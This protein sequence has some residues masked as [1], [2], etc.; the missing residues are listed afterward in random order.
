MA[1]RSD[2]EKPS[3]TLL[4][5]RTM[6][7]LLTS[8]GMDSRDGLDE[9]LKPYKVVAFEAA[10]ASGLER[11]IRGNRRMSDKALSLSD[12]NFPKLSAEASTALREKLAKLKADSK[13]VSALQTYASD[14]GG[15][16]ASADE[17]IGY[18]FRLLILAQDLK[19]DVLCSF[20]RARLLRRLLEQDGIDLKET[21][22][23][24]GLIALESPLV[25]YPIAAPAAPQRIRIFAFDDQRRQEVLQP[26][27]LFEPKALVR[28]INSRIGRKT[29]FIAAG[30]LIIGSMLYAVLE[31]GERIASFMAL[32]L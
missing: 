9:L 7:A 30:V 28:Y 31:N 20:P 17:L 22:L 23:T 10:G 19:A 26:W 18:G 2:T 15:T 29:A 3:D 12:R 21:S 1:A 25:S 27:N 32:F 11:N 8:D 14:T 16:Q 24:K 13:V 5:D 6:V 4:V